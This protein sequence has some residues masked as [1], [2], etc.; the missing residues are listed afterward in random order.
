[1]N[2]TETYLNSL[3]V[4]DPVIVDIYNYVPDAEV[5]L[6]TYIGE[7][8]GWVTD[9]TS[10]HFILEC[11][12]S[13]YEVSRSTGVAHVHREDRDS[14]QVSIT[15]NPND[16]EIAMLAH[17]TLVFFLNK[18]GVASDPSRNE[19][20][21]DRLLTLLKARIHSINSFGTTKEQP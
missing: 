17:A 1:M 12:H 4:G 19:A 8:L 6:G 9:I 7:L 10:L 11:G 5:Q 3:C 21:L 2:T 13:Q 16:V 15:I 20:T 18:R 14:I